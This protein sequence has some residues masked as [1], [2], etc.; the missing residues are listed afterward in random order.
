[1]GEMINA[2]RSSFKMDLKQMG[3]ESVDWIYLA[4]D[5]D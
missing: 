4:Q 1:M 3:R 5:A 2:K